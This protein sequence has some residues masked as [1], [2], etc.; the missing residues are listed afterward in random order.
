MSDMLEDAANAS[1]IWLQNS[2]RNRQ[3][4]PESNGFC[5]SCDEPTEGIFCSKE[6][7]EDHE[8]I[9]RAKKIGGTE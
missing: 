6:C 5:L 3:K 4:V 7:R 9:Q 2:L 1:E 8:R